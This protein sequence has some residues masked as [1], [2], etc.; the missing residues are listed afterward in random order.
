VASSAEL[1]HLAELP[2]ADFANFSKARALVNALTHAAGAQHSAN[3]SKLAGACKS[4]SD[5][6][7]SDSPAAEFLEHADAV[8]PSDIAGNEE[9]C[10]SNGLF[11]DDGGNV[12]NTARPHAEQKRTA[13][14]PGSAEISSQRFDDRRFI[15][16]KDI[17]F[18][19]VLVRFQASI[20]LA[21]HRRAVNDAGKSM[22]PQVARQIGRF[23]DWADDPIARHF[24]YLMVRQDLPNTPVRTLFGKPRQ[25][26]GISGPGIPSKKPGYILIIVKL[27]PGNLALVAEQRGIVPLDFSG[28]VGVTIGRA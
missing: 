10:L 24:A 18:W 5:E 4:G 2:I 22:R 12:V 11:A 1:A 21:R 28:E 26:H 25:G 14:V 15:G 19:R 16:P 7:L 27:N 23:R 6:C 3:A 9:Q 20:Q 13:P 8:N 17:D